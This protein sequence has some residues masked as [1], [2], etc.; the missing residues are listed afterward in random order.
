M[1]ITPGIKIAC[2]GGLGY[3]LGVVAK[4]DPKMT[5]LVWLVA[6]TVVQCLQQVEAFEKHRLENSFR[7]VTGGIACIYLNERH[8]VTKTVHAVFALMAFG[9]VPDMMTRLGKKIV[10]ASA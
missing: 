5:A 1:D 8:L 4:T 6:E 2:M 9:I 10:I 3:T 7:L